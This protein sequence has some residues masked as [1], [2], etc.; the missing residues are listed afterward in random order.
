[1]IILRI[2]MI[3]IIQMILIMIALRVS[4]IKNNNVDV[5]LDDREDRAG[6]KFKDAELIGIPFQVIV[7]RDSVNKEI[8]FL[9][10]SNDIKI[11]IPINKLLETFFSESK[12]MYKKNL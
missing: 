3:L 1:M 8:E 9:C 5:L 6:I 7:G 11:K 4:M 2:L 12:V 10:R